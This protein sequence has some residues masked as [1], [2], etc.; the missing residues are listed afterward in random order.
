MNPL[1]RAVADVRERARR[2]VD[3]RIAALL[4][5]D[6]DAVGQ[7]DDAAHRFLVARRELRG[8]FFRFGN[9]AALAS[10]LLAMCSDLSN[11]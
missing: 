7:A 4:G 3:V 1:A 6:D 10:I 5:G 8:D 9:G 11:S 2:D